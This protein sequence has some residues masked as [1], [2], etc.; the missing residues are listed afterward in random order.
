MVA[1]TEKERGAGSTGSRL[2]ARSRYSIRE[3]LRLPPL[4]G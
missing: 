4:R 3:G 1:R 2:G